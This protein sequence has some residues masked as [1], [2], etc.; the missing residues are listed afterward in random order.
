MPKSLREI[1]LQTCGAISA[2]VNGYKDESGK[3]KYLAA[4]DKHGI[5]EKYTERYYLHDQ[6]QTNPDVEDFVDNLLNEEKIHVLTLRRI[7]YKQVCRLFRKLNKSTHLNAQEYR[8]AI[9]SPRCT[10]LRDISNT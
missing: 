4:Y 6:D 7:T 1:I 10:F 8:Q 5:E 2:F 3:V 9:P